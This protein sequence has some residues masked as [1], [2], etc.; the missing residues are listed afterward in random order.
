MA[1]VNKE[2]ILL[3]WAKENP[4][5]EDKTLLNFL[6]D[7]NGQSAVIP[8]EETVSQDYL[9]GSKL[10]YYDFMWSVI[11]DI[12]ETTDEINVRSMFELR[13]WQDWIDEQNDSGGLPDFGDGYC[14]EEIRNLAS[15]GLAMIYEGGKGKYQ[16]PVRLVYLRK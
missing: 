9:D 14:M 5:L 13:K 6:G 10:V 7:N 4:L 15:P 3:E 2:K 8:I 12:S 16:F 1:T 11:F